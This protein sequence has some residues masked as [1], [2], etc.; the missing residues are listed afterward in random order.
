MIR[1]NPFGFKYSEL[2]N[3]HPVKKR[4][5]LTDEE[6]DSFVEFLRVRN[7]WLLPHTII[8]R[9]T[10]IRLGELIGLTVDDVDFEN[11]L[12]NID[13]QLI[14][15]DKRFYV[16]TPKTK[17]SINKIPLTKEAEE[18]LQTLIVTAPYTL[19]ID[20][21]GGFFVLGKRR[22]NIAQPVSIER[23][24]RW[25]TK[26]YNDTYPEHQIKVSPHILRHSTPAH[27]F[28]L[29]MTVPFV[30]RMMRH[31]KADMTMEVYTHLSTT[32]LVEEL[33]GLN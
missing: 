7:D 31:S 17:S 3:Q 8:M 22:L 27:F 19:A 1:S 12:L 13:K 32:D 26:E 21:V 16:S 11:H 4:Q 33:R 28:K 23:H 25:L 20:D 5:G 9:D 14:Y 24:Y 10:G 30:Q 15:D 29:G 2:I 18:A 6:F